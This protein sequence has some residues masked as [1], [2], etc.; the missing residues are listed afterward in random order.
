VGSIAVAKRATG[1]C[2][3]DEIGVCYEIYRIDWRPGYSFIFEQG[4]YDGF[5]PDEVEMMLDVTGDVCQVVADY[6]FTD[7]LQL[8]EDYCRG[9]FAPAFTRDRGNQS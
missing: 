1:V 9:R 7:V 4:R 5:S 2:D 3:V 8:C 6:E